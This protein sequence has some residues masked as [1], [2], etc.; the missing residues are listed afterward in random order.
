MSDQLDEDRKTLE[1]SESVAG[2]DQLLDG[3]AEPNRRLDF[4][5]LVL[6]GGIVVLAC[7][8]VLPFLIKGLTG[9]SNGSREGSRS[10][11]PFGDGTSGYNDERREGGNPLIVSSSPVERGNLHRERTTQYIDDMFQDHVAS[12]RL[13]D[14]FASPHP[15]DRA[16]ALYDLPKRHSAAKSMISK[17]LEDESELVRLSAARTAFEF[18]IDEELAVGQ[19]VGLLHSKD[20]TIQTGTILM[21]GM[22]GRRAESSINELMKIV[23]DEKNDVQQRSSAAYSI[24]VILSSLSSNEPTHARPDREEPF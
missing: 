10:P 11:A 2:I 23:A 20:K 6:A 9:S 24:A 12:A 1:K 5:W 8:F 17:G 18:D 3:L 13:S 22:F 14:R 7:A 4:S 15:F 16:M 21:L 19:L